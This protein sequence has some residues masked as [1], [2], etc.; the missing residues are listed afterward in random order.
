MDGARAGG[1]HLGK[2]VG[3][4]TMLIRDFHN[5]LAAHADVMRKVS[6][7]A[8]QI[9]RA[10]EV[11]AQAIDSGRKILVCGNGGSAADAQ[12]FA[13]ELIGRFERERRAWPGLA[14]T[15]DTSIMTAVGNDYGF[16]TV[17][18]RQVE[19]L[20]NPGD[21]LVCI[22]TSG[23]SPNVLKAAEVAT[24]KR[25]TTIGLLGKSGGLISQLVEHS[26]VIQ[27]PVTA[28]IQEA[29]EFILH[30]WARL[31]EDQCA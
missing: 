14:L 26:I 28:R 25:M 17:F 30:F 24:S 31:I 23:N 8:E 13:A 10:G 27:D 3:A 9:V 20:G 18:S 15:T 7:L 6:S 12:H 16:E 21:I 4:R 5:Q 1:A 11:M 29:H 2:A 22:S 19:A